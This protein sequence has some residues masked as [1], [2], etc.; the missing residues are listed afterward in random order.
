MW[1]EAFL[2]RAGGYLILGGDGG[3]G[4]TV[5]LVNLALHMAAG[6]AEF[7]GFK[8]P[9][10]R[11]TVLFIEAEG[12]RSRFR[13]WIGKIARE[14]RYEPTDLPIFFKERDA[15][16]DLDENLRQMITE[17]QAEFVVLDPIGSFFEGNENLTPEWRA[18]VT[19]KLRAIAEKF[20]VAFAFSDHFVKPAANQKDQTRAGKH[21]MRGA[22]AKLDDA[23][24]IMRLEIGAGGKASRILYFDRVRDGELPDPDRIGLTINLK[25]GTIDIDQI[26]NVADIP[27]LHEVRQSRVADLVREIGGKNGGV[28]STAMLMIR[29]KNDLQLGH[30]QAE[31][32]IAS[33]RDAGL[34]ERFRQG[35]YRLPGEIR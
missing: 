28:A 16:I 12:S 29:L 9:G 8:L 7:L 34:I 13:D 2:V 35:I 3:V 10:R 17:T 11:V 14:I 5:L 18:G 19:R 24:A 23:G 33:A 22:G 32:L 15:A 26:A 21:K 1:G 30:T 6:D 27:T 31:T 4:K 25:R 20:S